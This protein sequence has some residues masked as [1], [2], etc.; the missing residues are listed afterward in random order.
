M[1]EKVMINEV[2]TSEKLIAITFDDGPNTI[3]TPQVLDI[4]SEVD[5]KATFFMIGE[6]IEK[7]PEL[8]KKAYELGHEIGNHTYTHPKLSQ[9]SREDCFGEIER[10]K[11]LITELVGHK[12]VVFRPPYLDFNDETVSVL[13]QMGYPMIGALN[14]EAKDWEMPGVDFILEETRYC[15]KNGSILIFHDGYG[16]RSQT[17]EAVRILVSELTTQGY[18]LVTVS[19]LLNHLYTE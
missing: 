19:E 5:G 9:L 12:P 14:M 4:F 15:V 1:A 18:K 8:V 17:V 11:K 16:D 6:Q 10:T 2:S 3:F 7:C 13:N